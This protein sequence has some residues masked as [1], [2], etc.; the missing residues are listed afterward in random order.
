[1]TGTLNLL[2]FCFDLDLFLVSGDNLTCLF[3]VS[4]Y[5][6]YLLVI[7]CVLCPVVLIINKGKMGNDVYRYESA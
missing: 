7:Q 4:S 1:M 2:F 5:T 6:I 3:L